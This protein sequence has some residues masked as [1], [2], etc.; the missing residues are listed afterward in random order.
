M[1]RAVAPSW[2]VPQISREIAT[3]AIGLRGNPCESLNDLWTSR[4]TRTP[5]IK[6]GPRRIAETQRS[7]LFWRARSRPRANL[8][9]FRNAGRP[10]KNIRVPR[11]RSCALWRRLATVGM[12]SRQ[13]CIGRPV[14]FIRGQSFSVSDSPS[15]TGLTRDA[16]EIPL[17]DHCA[18]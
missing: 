16:T 1:M 12:K 7:L 8:L 2:G 14:L 4:T 9:D 17:A 6:F 10:K 5:L 3:R 15:I 11:T 18:R 13:R